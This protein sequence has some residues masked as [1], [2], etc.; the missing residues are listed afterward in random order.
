MNLEIGNKSFWLGLHVVKLTE[1]LISFEY[2]TRL[3]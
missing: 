1:R 2:S 3:V